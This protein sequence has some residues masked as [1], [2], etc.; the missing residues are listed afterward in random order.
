MLSCSSRIV[1]RLLFVALLFVLTALPRLHATV[2]S[3]EIAFRPIV[4]NAL[5]LEKLRIGRM[6]PDKL[7]TKR[8]LLRQAIRTALA[9]HQSHPES[10]LRWDAAVFAYSHAVAYLNSVRDYRMDGKERSRVERVAAQNYLAAEFSEIAPDLEQARALLK[11]ADPHW[12]SP[13]DMDRGTLARLVAAHTY[14]LWKVGYPD[15]FADY[16]AVGASAEQVDQ[17]VDEAARWIAR[18]EEAIP[19]GANGT[20]P[21]RHGLWSVDE[22]YLD[23]QYA[24][25]DMLKKTRN[26]YLWLLQFKRMAQGPFAKGAHRGRNY[27]GLAR[28]NWGLTPETE[29]MMEEEVRAFPRTGSPSVYGDS[30]GRTQLWIEEASR[31][32]ATVEQSDGPYLLSDEEGRWQA[33]S[34]LE[35]GEVMRATIEKNS[36][37]QVPAV[38]GRPSFEVQL[39]TSAADAPSV[40]RWPTRKRVFLMADTHGEFEV[41][42]EFLIRQEVVDENLSWKFG[43]GHMVVLGDIFDRGARQA[44]ILWLLYKL[45]AEAEAHGGRVHV[46]LGNHE[47]MALTG[48]ISNLNPR[49]LRVAAALGVAEYKTLFAK[50]T[51]L[52]QWLRSKA[53]VLKL[54][55]LLCMHGGLSIGG[56]TGEYTIEEI[57]QTVRTW[58]K[59]EESLTGD[60]LAFI[61]GSN[62]PLWYRGLVK[63]NAT[64][65]EVEAIKRFYGAERIAVGHTIVPSV[66]VLYESSV[67]AVQVYPTKDKATGKMN[68]EGV[69]IDEQG[70]WYKAKIDGTREILKNDKG[71]VIRNG[72]QATEDR[73]RKVDDAEATVAKKA[74]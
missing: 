57:N 51:L 21:M 37:I 14:Y 27:L 46:L 68:M 23:A 16:R 9:F 11:L 12:K 66:E 28:R 24:Y 19:E 59:S 36:R 43:D 44:E 38:N 56:V 18:V 60:R 29:K 69:Y 53:T 42:T 35:S 45:E 47:T 52:G 34:V 61:K 67:V 58:L 50:D 1:L 10:P 33:R 54:G 65:D 39:R 20:E 25:N 63:K 31:S 32:P 15:S 13:A 70:V 41:M 64:R 22:S 4:E 71:E 8:P 40:E 49:Y 72:G 74:A 7:A 55:D 2:A 3:D 30:L 62:G 73:E 26:E 5:A 17:L 48:V 6:T